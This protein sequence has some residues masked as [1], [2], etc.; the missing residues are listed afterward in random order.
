MDWLAQRSY[1]LLNKK[2]GITH[3]ARHSGE[4]PSVIDLLFANETAYNLKTFKDWAIN[5]S[6]AHD[7]DHN[8]IRYTIDHGRHEID[9]ILGV[10]QKLGGIEDIPEPRFTLWEP[11]AIHRV[12]E[13]ASTCV[14]CLRA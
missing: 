9:N 13:A 10:Y 12:Q 7:S 5:P 4:R 14:L 6:I 2:G 8:V 1:T 11:G 3:L